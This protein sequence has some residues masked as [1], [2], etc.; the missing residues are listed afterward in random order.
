MSQQMMKK[1][2]LLIIKLECF[3]FLLLTTF[4][5]E[6]DKFMCDTSISRL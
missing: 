3:K 4:R 5:M 6:Y 2:Y 1:V